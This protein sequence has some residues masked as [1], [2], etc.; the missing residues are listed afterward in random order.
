M[1]TIP[2]SSVVPVIVY[3]LPIFFFFKRKKGINK[4]FSF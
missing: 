3:V 1:Y 2:G 4:K